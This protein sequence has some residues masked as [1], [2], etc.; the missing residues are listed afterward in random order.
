M[1]REI[2]GDVSNP[3]IRVG[4]KQWYTVPLSILAHVVAIAALVVIPL[5]ATDMIPTPQSVLAFAAMPPPPPPVPP[6]P[7]PPAAPSTPQVITNVNPTAAPVEAPEKIKPE[8]PAPPSLNTGGVVGGVP[9]GIPGGTP[10][11]ILGGISA[12]PP[13]PP[14]PQ[15]PIRVGGDI[16]EPRIVKKIDPTYPAL[17]RQ[18]KVQ[19]TVTIEATIGKDG[20]VKDAHVLAPVPLLDQAAL[21]AVKQ[22]KYTPTLLAGVPI[23]VLLIVRVNFTLR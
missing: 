12:P 13:P 22:W 6:P 19:G 7:P 2:F 14:P 1:P 23:E 15:A 5:L 10:G 4:T 8:P 3:T 20:S 16:K 21:D 17:A 18:A 11:G 9:G